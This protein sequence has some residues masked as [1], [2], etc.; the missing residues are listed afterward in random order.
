MSAPI[1]QVPVRERFPNRYT[2]GYSSSIVT[3]KVKWQTISS[4]KASQNSQ[5]TDMGG[6][7]VIAK[8]TSPCCVDS[9]PK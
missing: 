9:A 2:G 3:D 5:N 6:E 1:R 8:K 4:V 7:S